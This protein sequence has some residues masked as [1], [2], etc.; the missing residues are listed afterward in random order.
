[1]DRAIVRRHQFR[2]LRSLPVL[3]A[4]QENLYTEQGYAVVKA[5]IMRLLAE[6]RRNRASDL[7]QAKA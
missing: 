4:I 2:G 6:H 7:V 3:Q 5:V 1:M